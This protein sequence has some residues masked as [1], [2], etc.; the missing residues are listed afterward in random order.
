VQAVGSRSA[1]AAAV[2][3]VDVA[4]SGILSPYFWQ[5]AQK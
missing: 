2:R 3:L 4:A 5:A 1:G